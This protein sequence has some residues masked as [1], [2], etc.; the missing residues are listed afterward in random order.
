MNWTKVHGEDTYRAKLS[1]GLIVGV[2]K[3]T[4]NLPLRFFRIK[5][6]GEPV[7]VRAVSE[8]Q[9]YYYAFNEQY[10]VGAGFPGVVFEPKPKQLWESTL[11][12]IKAED[13]RIALYLTH[14]DIGPNTGGGVI[15]IVVDSDKTGVYRKLS[16][17][18]RIRYLAKKFR[19]T[20]GGRVKILVELKWRLSQQVRKSGS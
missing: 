15:Q 18:K 13:P 2:K 1:S 4:S 19:E 8:K 9:A 14:A 6:K 16:H 12:A 11:K 5:L 17:P 20:F 3:S 7:R 10:S